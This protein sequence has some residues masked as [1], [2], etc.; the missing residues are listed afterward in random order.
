MTIELP[1]LILLC[2]CIALLVFVIMYF[3]QQQKKSTL[4][5]NF[6]KKEQELQQQLARLSQEKSVSE[7]QQT[8][9]T[10]QLSK[11]EA[12]NQEQQERIEVILQ[13]AS[14][15]KTEKLSL[16]E[17]MKNQK[18]DLETLEE[19]F[20]IQFENV[21]SKI[22]KQNTVDFSETQQKS[23][24]E[25]LNPL[26][27]KINIF[28]KR[29]EETYEKG[30]KDQ[31]DMRAELKKL[32]EL[33]SRISLEANNLTKALKSD[34]KQQGNWGELVLE[35]IL[36]RSGLT[37]GEEYDRE[38]ATTNDA[39]ASIRPDVVVRL[40]E[41]KHIIIDSKVS[42]VAYEKAVNTDDET[43]RQSHIKEHV[44]SIKRHVKLLADKHYQSSPSLH[45][46]DF[47]LLFVP[48]E[49]S[50]ALAV[51]Q[52]GELFNLA[53][54]NKI[55]IVSPSTLLATL[56]TVSSIWK[57]EQQTRNVQEIARQGGA[58][59]DKFVNFYTDLEKVGKKMDEAK[60]AYVASM[61]KLYDGNDNLVRKAERLKELGARSKKELPKNLRDRAGE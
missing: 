35:R 44:A 61:K 3:L 9:L 30:L 28:E 22:L 16:E 18:D 41:D 33:N 27:E 11:R 21:A 54:D 52:D 39:G 1:Y 50:F 43:E 25:L 15:L 42:L 20:R 46:P 55:V 17:L 59:Y 60:D 45:T 53:W 56:R 31:T 10:Q 51:Q 24:T 36:E 57:Q 58:L 6:H 23:M 7:S 14:Q 29:V 4:T 32:Y 49:S 13:E 2:L 5:A 12:E 47:V 48:V 26:K 8:Q 40:P 37:K 38:V 19:R 34:S